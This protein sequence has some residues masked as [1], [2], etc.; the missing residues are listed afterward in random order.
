MQDIID[1]EILELKLSS[2]IDSSVITDDAEFELIVKALSSKTRRIILNLLK[3]RPMDVSSLATELKMT[4]ANISAQI[5]KLDQASLISCRYTSGNHG[6]RKISVL[7]WSK[8]TLN[9]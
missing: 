9:F 3:K 6:V 1:N 5:K 2:D 7:R 8:L 4:E